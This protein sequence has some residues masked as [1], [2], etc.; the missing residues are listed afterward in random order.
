MGMTSYGWRAGLILLFMLQRGVVN[1]A[2]FQ[3]RTIE[4]VSGALMT[5]FTN[6]IALASPSYV[7]QP[8]YSSENLHAALSAVGAELLE[9]DGDMAFMREHLNCGEEAVKWRGISL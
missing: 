9:R 2:V 6:A 7:A 3:V 8:G 1:L 4:G 5:Y